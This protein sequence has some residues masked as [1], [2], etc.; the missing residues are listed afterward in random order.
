MGGLSG[1][2]IGG[3]TQP[4]CATSS[5]ELILT[6]VLRLLIRLSSSS[7]TL[8][9]AAPPCE[10]HGPALRIMATAR[11]GSLAVMSWIRVS[12]F[13]ARWRSCAIALCGVRPDGA[14]SSWWRRLEQEAFSLT[15]FPDVAAEGS[16]AAA[17]AEGSSPSRCS[18]IT[19]SIWGSGSRKGSHRYPGAGSSTGPRAAAIVII[20]NHWHSVS[21]ART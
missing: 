4:P 14:S 15:S 17:A 16:S 1:T 5:L 9:A 6:V 8:L 7:V 2:N 12:I 10:W 11:A 21:S 18:S 3:L 13:S 20:I 19:R